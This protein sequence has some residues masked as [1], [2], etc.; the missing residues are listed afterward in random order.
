MWA[1]GENGWMS[2]LSQLGNNTGRDSKKKKRQVRGKLRF[3]YLII[4]KSCLIVSL[5]L[6]VVRCLPASEDQ[7]E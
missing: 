7:K 5:S 2:L 6:T 3:L 1:K 4:K